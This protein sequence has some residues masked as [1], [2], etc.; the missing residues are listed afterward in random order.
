MSLPAGQVFEATVYHGRLLFD[1][2]PKV[3]VRQ[4]YLY[5]MR[6]LASVKKDE[7]DQTRALRAALAL[8]MALPSDTLVTADIVEIGVNLSRH[9]PRLSF[10]AH[11]DGAVHWAVN[12]PFARPIIVTL[13]QLDDRC[14]VGLVCL[15]LALLLVSFVHEISEEIL[16][17]LRPPR[18]KPIFT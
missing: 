4:V 17:G 9:N 2:L 12:A 11:T 18:M 16:A 5:L 15:C 14:D 13:S 1:G 10:R 3:L 6:E 7:P 8:T